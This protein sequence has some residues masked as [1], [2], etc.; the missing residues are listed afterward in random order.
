VTGA[1]ADRHLVTV[2]NPAVAADTIEL[3]ARLLREKARACAAGEIEEDAVYVWWGKIRSPNRQQPLPHLDEIVALD[4]ALGHESDEADV[5]R[6]RELHLYVTD[7]RSLYVAHVGEVTA[8]DVRLWDGEH[9]HLPRM[10]DGV[11]CDC[12]FRLF[13]IRRLVAD[14]TSDVVAEL[15]KLRNVRYPERP[16]SIYGGMVDLPLIVRRPDGARWFDAATRDRLTDGRFW[17]EFDAEQSGVGAV[18]ASLRDDVL[19]ADAWSALDPAARL[20]VASAEKIFRDHRGDTAFDFSPVVVNLAKAYEVQCA[21]VFGALGG[22]VPEETWQFNLNGRTAHLLRDGPLGVGQLAHALGSEPRLRAAV[23]RWLY[24]G[25]W[26]ATSL[27][28]ILGEL[29]SV[30]GGGAH[31]EPVSRETAR[32]LRD[33]HLGVGTMGALVELARVRPLG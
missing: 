17:V 33:A 3:H 20:F 21:W 24:H 16:V 1:R 6:D 14:D 5:A 12:W 26:A 19:G 11:H 18:A 22:R 13:D 15:Q 28:P 23:E 27:G 7:Y 10:Y 8:D 29:A 32:R 4:A 9:A 2:W 30:R 25:R 31:T